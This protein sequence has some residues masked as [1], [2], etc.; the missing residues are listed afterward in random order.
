[1]TKGK[2]STFR[3]KYHLYHGILKQKR[4]NQRMG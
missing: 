4:T 1:M 2:H 3:A